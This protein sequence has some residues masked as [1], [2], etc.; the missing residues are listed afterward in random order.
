MYS[1]EQGGLGNAELAVDEPKLPW[2]RIVKGYSVSLSEVDPEN[3]PGRTVLKVINIAGDE[4]AI[5]AESTNEA[6]IGE[7]LFK[8][9]AQQLSEGTS[10]QDALVSAE[11]QLNGES[12]AFAMQKADQ[13]LLFVDSKLAE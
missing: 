4:G 5:Q 3:F 8:H 12:P 6:G 7:E 13:E 9:V 2:S 10:L 1:P 11:L